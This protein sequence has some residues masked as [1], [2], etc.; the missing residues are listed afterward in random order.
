MYSWAPAVHHGAGQRWH[1][2]GYP[3]RLGLGVEPER[4][5]M[6]PEPLVATRVT[7]DDDWSDVPTNIQ[8]LVFLGVETWTDLVREDHPQSEAFRTLSTTMW[9]LHRKR[10]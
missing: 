1:W 8:T 2:V 6:L 7:A 5:P 4:S 10:E 9:Q 3:R